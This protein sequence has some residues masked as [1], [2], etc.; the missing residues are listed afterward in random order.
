MST[1]GRLVKLSRHFAHYEGDVIIV[2]DDDDIGDEVNH[3]PQAGQVLL[4]HQGGGCK[5]G[6]NR[7][8]LMTITMSQWWTPKSDP[9]L[10]RNISLQ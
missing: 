10:A 3:L 2:D 4:G 8:N 5:E 9:P 6:Y 7:G 1:K